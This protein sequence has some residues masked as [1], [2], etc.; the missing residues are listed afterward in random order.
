MSLRAR[1]PRKRGLYTEGQEAHFSANI[2]DVGFLSLG[3]I[4]RIAQQS[5]VLQWDFFNSP[6]VPSLVFQIPRPRLFI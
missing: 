4:R 2:A 5:Q 1:L 6:A 3:A